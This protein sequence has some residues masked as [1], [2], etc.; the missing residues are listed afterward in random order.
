MSIVETPTAYPDDNP[1]TIF[2]SAKPDLTLI[3]PA[4][5]IY[6]A[7]AMGNGADKYGPYNWRA[8]RVSA[9][10]YIAAA[11]RHLSSW[12]DGEDNDDTPFINADGEVTPG[13]GLPHL[14]HAMASIAIV[15]DALE[16]GNLNDNRPQKGVAAQLIV[17][18]TKRMPKPEVAAA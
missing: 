8:K 13:S 12:L 2:G 7:L 11:M 5:L 15:V 3:P 14:A 6:C 10:T 16:T 9:R 4:A 1:K 17:K 18:Y